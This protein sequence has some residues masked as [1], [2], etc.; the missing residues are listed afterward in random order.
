MDLF[1]FWR[2]GRFRPRSEIDLDMLVSRRPVGCTGGKFFHQLYIPVST[3]DAV[4]A[5]QSCQ[6]SGQVRSAMHSASISRLIVRRDTSNFS[7]R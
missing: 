7:A 1:N 5:F 6:N 4:K 2:Q 3:A